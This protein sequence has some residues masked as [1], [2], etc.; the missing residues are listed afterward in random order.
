MDQGLQF[1]PISAALATQRRADRRQ[2]KEVWQAFRRLALP[3][4]DLDFI[5]T[6][7]W[8][9]LSVGAASGRSGPLFQIG[10]LLIAL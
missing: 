6:C 9:K 8:K 2:P 1:T 3:P 10:A 5:H 7:L 4:Q